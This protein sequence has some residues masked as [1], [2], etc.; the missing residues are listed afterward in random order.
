MRAFDAELYALLFPYRLWIAGGVSLV[1]FLVVLYLVSTL[2]R[3][4][5]GALPAPSPPMLPR[6][7]LRARVF[8]LKRVRARMAVWGQGKARPLKLKRL[9]ARLD[10]EVRQVFSQSGQAQDRYE[11]LMRGAQTA[12]TP[13]AVAPPAPVPRAP[14]PSPQGQL[15]LPG[16]PQAPPSPTVPPSQLAPPRKARRRKAVGAATP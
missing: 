12:P 9:I 4:I 13:P 15:P 3:P 8:R 5:I 11:A 7:P 10:P 2:I 16:V 6:L 14:A 1:A